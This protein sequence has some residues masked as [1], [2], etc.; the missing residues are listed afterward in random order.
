MN[1]L[2]NLFGS[3]PT[4]EEAKRGGK[5]AEEGSIVG[6]FARWRRAHPVGPAA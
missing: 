1:F 2:S 6:L 4:G 5:A 3:K